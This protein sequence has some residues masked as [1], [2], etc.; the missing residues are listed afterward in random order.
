M[1]Q[2]I[3]E[4]DQGICKKDINGILPKYWVV[5]ESGNDKLFYLMN[6]WDTSEAVGSVRIISEG[7]Y[8]KILIAVDET[9]IC[10][11]GF[12]SDFA[13]KYNEIDPFGLH[14][15]VIYLLEDQTVELDELSKE[16][17][18][19]PDIL[20]HYSMIKDAF[21]VSFLF[22]HWHCGES[23][24]VQTIARINEDGTIVD[25]PDMPKQFALRESEE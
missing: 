5:E 6:S 22:G 23:L 19:D 20:Q 8:E 7:V 21:L 9:D 13:M 4:M 25:A 14:F 3:F 2:I 1:F 15:G 24:L 11:K 17:S 18:I 10:K 12:W 16:Q